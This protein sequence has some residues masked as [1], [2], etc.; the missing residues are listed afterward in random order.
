MGESQANVADSKTDH[1]R[2]QKER[3]ALGVLVAVALVAVGVVIHVKNT[4][5][6]LPPTPTLKATIVPGV[7]SQ[8]VVP[9]HTVKQGATIGAKIVVT[10][11]TGH[12]IHTV[13]CDGLNI[14]VS[15]RSSKA[16]QQPAFADCATDGMIPNGKSV[17]RVGITATYSACLNHQA[18]TDRAFPPCD[19]HG[20]I[21]ALPKGKYLAYVVGATDVIS[22]ALPVQIKVT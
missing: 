7:T 22:S 2:S 8:L 17:F 13:G 5:P 15:L 20:A 14:A 16:F 1:R 10:N 18:A 11:A 21:P 3:I 9:R 12:V 6:G 19:E 4:G